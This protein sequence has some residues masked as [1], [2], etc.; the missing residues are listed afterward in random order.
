MFKLCIIF[1]VTFQISLMCHMALF[2]FK[3]QNLVSKWP[4]G[5]PSILESFPLRYNNM[6]HTGS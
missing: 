6:P 2:L 5:S 4:P 3:K 1:R